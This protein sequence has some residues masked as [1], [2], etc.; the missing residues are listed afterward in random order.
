[1]PWKRA[2]ETARSGKY[3]ATSF[4]FYSQDREA[5]FIHSDPVMNMK[6]VFFHLRT[7]PVPEDWS[8]LEQLRGFRIGATRGYTY[9]KDFWE[10]AQQGTLQVDVV[11]DDEQNMRKLLAGRIQAFPIDELT[12]WDL[13]NRKF[14]PAQKDLLTTTRRPLV[15]GSGYLLISRKFPNATQLAEKFNAG[16]KMLKD[17][18]L[19]E[20]YQ[21]DLISGKY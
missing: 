12:G 14:A 2:M 19:L 9:T 17:E 8:S 16:L 13:L 18:G 15:T 3:A 4:W 11:T 1:M 20:H 5:D 6:T 21:D 10:L 7:T